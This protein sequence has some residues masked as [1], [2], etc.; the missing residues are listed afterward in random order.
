MYVVKPDRPVQDLRSLQYHICYFD[1]LSFDDCFG[2]EKFSALPSINEVADEKTEHC[3]MT[4]KFVCHWKCK[5]SSAILFL[6][7]SQFHFFLQKIH[8]MKAG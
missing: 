6:E 5:F 1:L 8:Q 4:R 3:N 2:E 7:G